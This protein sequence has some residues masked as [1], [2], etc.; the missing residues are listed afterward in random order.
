MD[1]IARPLLYTVLEINLGERR[2]EI[3]TVITH[4]NSHYRGGVHIVPGTVIKIFASLRR[5]CVSTIKGEK[6]VPREKKSKA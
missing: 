3:T 2:I 6:I 4:D 1:G 5:R